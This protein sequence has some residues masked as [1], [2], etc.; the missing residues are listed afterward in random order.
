MCGLG[1]VAN[2]LM[3]MIAN[4]VGFC[5]GVDGMV[6]MLTHIFGTVDGKGATIGNVAKG[7][8]LIAM[9]HFRINVP[10]RGDR[11]FIYRSANHV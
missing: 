1:A 2:I 6:D 3:M 7:T 10:C 4:L 8:I 9:N 5:V 11:M